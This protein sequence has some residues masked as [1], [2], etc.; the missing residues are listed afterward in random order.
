MPKHLLCTSPNADQLLVSEGQQWVHVRGQPSTMHV[1]K[2][3]PAWPER[4]RARYLLLCIGLAGELIMGGVMFGWNALSVMLKEESVY[5]EGCDPDSD[6]CSSQDT[7][8]NVVWTAG[9]F[10]VNFGIA[11]AGVSVDYVGPK[12]TSSAGAALAAAGL[13]SL[14]ARHRTKGGT[15]VQFCVDI[16]MNLRAQVKPGAGFDQGTAT[17][18]CLVHQLTAASSLRSNVTM[19][20]LPLLLK[21]CFHCGFRAPRGQLWLAFLFKAFHGALLDKATSH[22]DALKCSNW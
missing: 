15:I 6:T 18:W 16:L 19:M 10:A 9:V 1:K 11:F 17:S 21:S 5:A 14:G 3:A 13:I 8:L 22:Q 4:P 20:L 12:F 7:K 2:E